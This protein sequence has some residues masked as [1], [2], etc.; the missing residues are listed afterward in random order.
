MIL[1]LLSLVVV[2][3]LIKLAEKLRRDHHLRP[4]VTRKFVH[5]TVGTFVAFWPFFMPDWLIYL[6]CVA[7]VLVV[8]ASRYL[9]WFNSIH[10]IERRT[11]GDILF[12]IGIATTLFFASSDWIFVV[13]MLHLGLADGLAALIGEKWGN[14]TVYKVAGYKK[15]IVG[16]IA[17]LVTS[18]MILS[19]LVF[20]LDVG[21]SQLGL[22]G[23]IWVPIFATFFEAI[24]VKGS[25]NL[26][27]PIIIV[28]MLNMLMV[29]G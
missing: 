1:G 10:A 23:I 22:A 15:S 14:K 7:F 4:E 11:W 13:A 29:V 2:Y 9:G 28:W 21:F 3:C 18:M 25:D 27:V 20:V 8:L 24:S 26:V 16:N 6:A 12:P 5:I 19:V 17:F